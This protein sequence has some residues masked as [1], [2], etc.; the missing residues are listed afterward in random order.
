MLDQPGF[1]NSSF[2]LSFV[3]AWPP[4]VAGK[5]LLFTQS[6]AQP[7]AGPPSGILQSLNSLT[8]TH[9]TPFLRR[10]GRTSTLQEGSEGTALSAVAA[11]L[12][13]DL[14]PPAA[15]LRANPLLWLDTSLHSALHSPEQRAEERSLNLPASPMLP[16]SHQMTAGVRS[17]P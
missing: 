7:P 6:P 5:G 9:T 11:S 13:R 17:V 15:E 3:F 12:L 14:A 10:G 4:W 8:S 16:A 1:S 2:R